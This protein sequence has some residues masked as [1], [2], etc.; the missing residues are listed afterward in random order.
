MYRGLAVRLG[1]D[2]AAFPLIADD[3][4]GDSEYRAT[5]GNSK[6]WQQVKTN[7]FLLL[8]IPL[9]HN[10]KV[11]SITVSG[12]SSVW[13]W[14]GYP[15]PTG[16]GRCGAFRVHCGFDA[17]VGIPPTVLLDFDSL[18][19]LTPSITTLRLRRCG[20]R[21][22]NGW[23]LDWSGSWFPQNVKVLEIDRSDFDLA[24]MSLVYA[25]AT[26]R[27]VVL[28]FNLPRPPMEVGEQVTLA[29]FAG[30]P[31]LE[32]LCVD[33]LTTI[34]SSKDGDDDQCTL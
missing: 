19:V 16:G 33:G 10:L 26:L 11:L 21:G 32:R 1:F 25:Q 4:S 14:L 34:V 12:V 7:A 5:R 22:Y 20:F 3:C 29:D 17:G 18:L 31:V 30:F 24:G 23:R 15:S 28:Q 27:D 9:L 13:D 8:A 2:L 6:R